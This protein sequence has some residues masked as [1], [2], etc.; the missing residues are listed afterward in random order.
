MDRLSSAHRQG[1]RLALLFDYDGTLTPI[2]EHPALARLD[3]HTARLLQRLS[4]CPGVTVGVISGRGLDDLRGMVGLPGLYYAGNSGLE[5]DLLGKRLTYPEAE[6][7]QGLMQRLV[8]R[9]GAIATDYA[10]AWVEDKRLGLT[11][12]YRQAAP[13]RL[14]DLLERAG[15]VVR[16]FADRLRVVEGPMAWEI[17]PT[18]RWDK[19]SAVRLILDSVG[20]PVLP[21]YAG[22]GANDAEAVAAAAALRGVALGVGARA[23]AGCQYHLPDPAAFTSFLTCLTE[24][25]GGLWAAPVA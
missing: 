19:G 22:D 7:N 20:P 24:S 14:A 17:T 2:V 21:V 12:H 5:L 6:A 4:G 15:R 13:H 25:L 10:G 23:P 18:L 16:A 8:R 3:P 9:L 11:L 1:V